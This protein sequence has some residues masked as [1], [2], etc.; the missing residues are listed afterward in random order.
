MAMVMKVQRKRRMDMKMKMIHLSDAGCGRLKLLVLDGVTQ[1]RAS[2]CRSAKLTRALLTLLPKLTIVA[3]RPNRRLHEKNRRPCDGVF[4][5]SWLQQ[6]NLFLA[7]Q[8]DDDYT[9][10]RQR[11]RWERR[12]YLVELQGTSKM[13]GLGH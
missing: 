4:G 12:N 3:P 11:L 6:K 9:K 5:P 10:V 1:R 8:G 2:D 13:T 7:A